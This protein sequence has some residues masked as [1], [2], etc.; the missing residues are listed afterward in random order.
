MV[1]SHNS[2]QC[3]IFSSIYQLPFNNITGFGPD[4]RDGKNI[5]DLINFLRPKALPATLPTDPVDITDTCIN[6]ARMILLRTSIRIGI[7]T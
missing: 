5:A 4:W 6:V 7:L 2:D 1:G 3:F